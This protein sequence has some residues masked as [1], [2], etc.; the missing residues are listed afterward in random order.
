MKKLLRLL[1]ISL[2]ASVGNTSLVY[3]QNEIGIIYVKSNPEGASVFVND[4]LKGTTPY[5]NQFESGQ[6]A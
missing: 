6:P 4:E 3:S 5:Q 2:M 1:L